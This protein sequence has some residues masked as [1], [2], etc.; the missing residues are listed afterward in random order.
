MVFELRGLKS[1]GCSFKAITLTFLVLIIINLANGQKIKIGENPHS[2][3]IVLQEGPFYL[4][5]DSKGKLTTFEPELFQTENIHIEYDFKG[6]IKRVDSTSVHYNLDGRLCQIGD[7]RIDY[8]VKGR[9]RQVGK[10]RI[11]YDMAGR[12]RRV[13]SKRV[14]Y[15]FNGRLRRKRYS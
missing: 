9:V 2:P 11:D 8:D 6:R 15:D 13:G 12:I 1:Q 5:I 14:D 3:D 4:V 7:A 10:H